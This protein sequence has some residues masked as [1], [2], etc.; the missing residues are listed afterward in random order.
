M[1]SRVQGTMSPGERCTSHLHGHASSDGG[2]QAGVVYPARVLMATVLQGRCEQEAPGGAVGAIAALLVSTRQN[3][4]HDIGDLPSVLWLLEPL[5]PGVVWVVVPDVA[6][7]L[8]LLSFH[9]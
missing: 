5:S 4:L 9:Q 1:G 7:Q 6:D 2:L 8:V 3:V